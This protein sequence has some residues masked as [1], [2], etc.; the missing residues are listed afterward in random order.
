MHRQ[1]NRAP[2][3]GNGAC[4][5]LADPPR[6]VCRELESTTELETIDRLHQSKVAF[7]DDVEE[8]QA[9]IEVPLGDRDDK[10]E[11]RFHQLALRFPY[12]VVSCA[13]ASEVLAELHLAH[14]DA[15]LELMAPV[16]ALAAR[17]FLQC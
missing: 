7:L 13:D 3:V 8:R 2:M 1:T 5:R 9:A 14:A 16:G 6:R 12:H 4:D 10:A 17:H 15:R 11:V